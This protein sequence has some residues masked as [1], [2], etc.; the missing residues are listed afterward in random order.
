MYILDGEGMKVAL[1]ARVST[2]EQTTD[3]QM[4]RL[5]EHA[6]YMK[7][8]VYD[9]YTDVASGMKSSRPELDRMLADA[10]KHKF[11]AIVAV[12]LDR[13]GRSVTNL[14]HIIEEMKR[15]GVSVVFLDQNIDT[16]SSMG[17][18]IIVILSGVAEFERN[19]IVERTKD[20]L[21]RARKE[22]KTLGR[23]R[24]TLSKYQID[25]AKAIIAEN[26]NISQRKFAEQFDGIGRKQLIEQLTQLGIWPPSGSNTPTGGVYKGG[27]KKTVGE[28]SDVSEPTN[29]LENTNG[30]IE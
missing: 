2:D 9:K 25:K 5:E 27:M 17:Q 14:L 29:D 15:K 24:N 6:N 7:Y 30:A 11:D 3:N 12:K 28:Q 1:Y 21:E 16:G 13:L 4:I 20:G 8:E 26:P 22:G 19:L 23:P 18:L 10:R